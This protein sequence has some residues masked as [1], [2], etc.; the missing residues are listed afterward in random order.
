MAVLKIRDENGNIIGIPALKGDNGKSAYEIAVDKGFEGT[1]EEWLESLKGAGGGNVDITEEI[2]PTVPDWAKQKEKPSYAAN[3]IEYST[4]ISEDINDVGE[5]LDVLVEAVNSAGATIDDIYNNFARKDDIPTTAEDV[6]ALPDTTVIPTKTSQLENDNGYVVDGLY[7]LNPR[8]KIL[9]GNKHQIDY[10]VVGNTICV[11]LWIDP[12][13]ET[14]N[15]D[16]NY[17]EGYN[18]N[19][20][21]NYNPYDVNNQCKTPDEKI[22]PDNAIITNIEFYVENMEKFVS[23]EDVRKTDKFNYVNY[24]GKFHRPYQD[25]D[26]T[27]M[28]II[29]EIWVSALNY[30]TDA[31]G[32]YGVGAVV[33]TYYLDE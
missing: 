29:A 28:Y 9:D 8:K 3:E 16:P 32:T 23:I 18:P 1:E 7:N 30:L 19:S 24:M 33:I 17:E 5:A 21:P 6:G 10:V 11:G 4:V 20:D 31:I 22:I 15:I 2:D 12:S 13:D 26:N 25:N 14:V 27:G